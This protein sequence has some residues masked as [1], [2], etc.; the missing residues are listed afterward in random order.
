LEKE[1]A[2]QKPKKSKQPLYQKQSFWQAVIITVLGSVLGG[3]IPIGYDLYKAHKQYS[4]QDVSVQKI[5]ASENSTY[6]L[7]LYGYNVNS[8]MF[9]LAKIALMKEGYTLTNSQLFQDRRRYWLARTPTVLYYDEKTA[10]TAWLIAQK[11]KA[12]TGKPFDCQRGA[13]LGVSKEDAQ[14]ELKIHLVL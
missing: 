14:K 9:N 4:S 2:Q 3:M 1:K 13:G 6:S 7:A 11:L 5:P 8:A 12:V 10:P